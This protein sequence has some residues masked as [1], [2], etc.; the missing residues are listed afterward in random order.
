MRENRHSAEGPA[1]AFVYQFERALNWLAR[2]SAGCS[3]GI[4]T[5]DDISVRDIDGT[6]LFEQDK[7]V[8]SDGAQP[9][10]DRS[11]GLWKTL[12]IWLEL[13]GKRS[14]QIKDSTSF[15]FVTNTHVPP[16]IARR[17]ADAQV[18]EAVDDCVAEL[19]RAGQDPPQHIA[20]Y[21][22]RVLKPEY[23]ALLREIIAKADLADT[24]CQTNWPD[25]RKSTIAH[26]QLPASCSDMSESITNELSGWLS[27]TV[28]TLWRN[29]QPGWI[30]RDHFVNEMHAVI[31]RRKREIRRERA[32]LL[33]PV[34]DENVGRELR[35]PFVRQLHLITDDDDAVAI[36]IREFIRCNTE[37][38]RLS[39]EGNITD[40]DWLAFEATLI[41][42]WNKIRS[43]IKRMRQGCDER[44][45]GFEL[46]AETTENYRERLAGMDT[47]QVY[48][49]SGTYHRLA[50]SLTVGWHPRFEELMRELMGEV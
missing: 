23:S 18:G 21:V 27:S 41:A 35:R 49:T 48:L 16:C 19:H 3:I 12:S 6:E 30:E 43:R 42:R 7:H 28:I 33:I 44:M 10:G 22:C 45:A 40:D 36:A 11:V 15:L 13:C 14:G 37:K 1:A 34:T 25:L 32:E 26:L 5:G 17:L 46:F 2:K 47:E 31:D 39:K 38:S 20:Q 50:D 29:G 9:F 8:L 4:E 24:S